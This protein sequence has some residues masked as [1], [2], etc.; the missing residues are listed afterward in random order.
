MRQEKPGRAQHAPLDL[1][2]RRLA[3]EMANDVIETVDR[4]Q[5]R[6]GDRAGLV[7]EH[8]ERLTLVLDPPGADRPKF[9]SFERRHARIQS[10]GSEPARQ[11]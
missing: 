1:D 8:H 11:R 9:R 3:V 10:L 5:H 7:F 4:D 2:Q 6:L